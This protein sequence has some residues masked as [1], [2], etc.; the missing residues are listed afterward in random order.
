METRGR[1]GLPPPFKAEFIA[2]DCSKVSA[3]T[4]YVSVDQCIQRYQEM[5]TRG[6]GGPPPFKAEFIAA[7]CSKVSADIAYVSMDQC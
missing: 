5:E 7:D 3:D 4:T 1:G 2:A 6:R